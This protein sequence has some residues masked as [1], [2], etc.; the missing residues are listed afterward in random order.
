MIAP[1][2][3]LG[4]EHRWE[5]PNC[6][7][8]VVLV[9]GHAFVSRLPARDRP[10]SRPRSC[11]NPVFGVQT[12]THTRRDECVAPGESREGAT[13]QK[14]Q[15][16]DNRVGLHR[17]RGRVST[18]R[19]VRPAQ[20]MVSELRACGPASTPSAEQSARQP[21]QVW[22]DARDVR[23]DA[24]GAGRPMR[25]LPSSD[26]GTI[27]TERRPLPRLGPGPRAALHGV[28]PSDWATPR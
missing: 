7:R 15:A 14:A 9:F 2:V 13:A 21:R 17:L 28:Q 18:S 3:L 4:T 12:A 16:S 26:V 20:D 6:D 22:A 24:R 25:H 19:P 27:R 23:A 5:C 8:R 10:S 1:G 11:A